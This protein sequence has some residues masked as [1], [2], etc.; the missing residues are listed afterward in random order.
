[1]RTLRGVSVVRSSGATTGE[2]YAETVVV[3]EGKLRLMEKAWRSD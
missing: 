3:V 2:G 1:M